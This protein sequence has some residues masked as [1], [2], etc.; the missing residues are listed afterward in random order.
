MGR[1]LDDLLE[2]SKAGQREDAVMELDLGALCRE[3]AQFIGPKPGFEVRVPAGLPPFQ[4]SRPA[5]RQVLQNLIGNALKHHDKES[6]LVELSA[7]DLGDSVEIRVKD[8]GPGID[9]RFHERIFQVFQTLRPKD[10]L[11]SNG[12]GLALVRKI[13]VRHGGSIRVESAPGAGSSFIFRWP[14]GR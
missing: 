6:G 9:P 12:I 1:L 3:V 11:D 14:K 8:D 5:L 7:V 4:A 10:E 2:F 13:L